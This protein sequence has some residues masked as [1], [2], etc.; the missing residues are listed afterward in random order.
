MGREKAIITAVVI[1]WA[2]EK[3][4]YSLHTAARKIGV[5]SE[6]LKEWEE[7]KSYPT[8][9]QA[10]K[11]SLTY[12]RPLA[13]FYLP[14]PP[15][16][17]PLLK[18]FRTVK[19]KPPKHSPALVFLIRQFQE[20]Q[21]W[22]R[23][24]LIEQGYEKLNFI[25]S[26]N[27]RSS[28]KTLSQNIIQVLW[29]GEK[30]YIQKKSELRNTRSLLESWLVQCEKNGIFI[31]R[32]NNLNPHNVIPVTEARGFVISDPYAPFI[33]VNSEDSS[34]A[35]LFTLLHEL[36]HLWLDVSGVP[37][38]LSV[39][40]K[41]EPS[42][43]EFFCNQIATEILIPEEK[44]KAFPKLRGIE[45]IKTFIIQHY[46]NFF[47]SR[48]SLL[49]RLKTFSLI[50]SSAFKE[51]ESYYEEE[52]RKYKEKKKKELKE[53]KGG[54]S[55]NLLKVKANGKSFTKIVIYSYKEGLIS[56]RQASDLLDMK[57][58]R[59]EKILPMLA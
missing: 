38:H 39:G 36:A 43:L 11:M 13:T 27:R 31:S 33:F 24:H 22:L 54:P 29:G 57:L 50:S 45:E 32:T 20:R 18:D 10:R 46:Q 35:Q 1:K 21:T 37:D 49:V 42:S 51:L 16:D 28:P 48:L 59:I 44:T 40:Y 25:G 7:G 47:V 19:G 4:H 23:E 55:A 3:S 41:G 52:Y 26:G 12:R 58:N 30:E 14:H 2:R 17:F 56:G 34:S 9:T 6:K 15:R 5:H 8:M 53:T